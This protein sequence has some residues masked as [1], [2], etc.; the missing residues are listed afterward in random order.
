MCAMLPDLNVITNNAA[1]RRSVLGEIPTG[2]SEN[3]IEFLD[4]LVVIGIFV[5]WFDFAG[6]W[7]NVLRPVRARLPAYSKQ[8]AILP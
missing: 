8:P 4:A 3:M 5:I 6:A 1:K 2:S 7:K